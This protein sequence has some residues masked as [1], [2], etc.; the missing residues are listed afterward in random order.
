MTTPQGVVPATYSISTQHSGLH[1]LMFALQL[2]E[3]VLLGDQQDIRYCAT[4]F[5]RAS[6]GRTAVI[7]RLQRD[8]SLVHLDAVAVDGHGDEFL[9]EPVTPETLAG[10]AESRAQILER[11][12]EQMDMLE[13]SDA[14]FRSKYESAS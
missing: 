9:P 1:I 11:Y 8:I 12:A 13:L 14:A 3:A 5:L 4:R 6:R 7:G 10:L 2:A